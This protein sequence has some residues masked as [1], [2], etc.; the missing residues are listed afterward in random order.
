MDYR[1]PTLFC[2]LMDIMKTITSTRFYTYLEKGT[3]T[4]DLK[5]NT[6]NNTISCHMYVEM[7]D[8]EEQVYYIH[9]LL[10]FTNHFSCL[11]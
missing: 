7:N 9:D 6:T 8:K 3:K 5:Y 10:G 1:I 11:K 4:F 2:V